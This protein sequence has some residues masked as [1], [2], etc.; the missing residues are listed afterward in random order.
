MSLERRL[1]EA[2]PN[3]A[4]RRNCPVGTRVVDLPLW[5][6]RRKAK[7]ARVNVGFPDDWEYQHGRVRYE[8]AQFDGE[9]DELQER[10]NRNT[11]IT[12]RDS[13]DMPAAA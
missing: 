2:H 10:R 4:Y 12:S 11:V 5:E 1:Q 8:R 13:E 9:I 3:S 6:T 7:D